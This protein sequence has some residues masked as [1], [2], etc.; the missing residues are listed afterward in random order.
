M[1]KLTLFIDNSA[2][3]RLY[4]GIGY[5][6]NRGIDVIRTPLEGVQLRARGD[7]KSEG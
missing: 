7:S 6:L 5:T 3:D 4:A 1:G 2:S